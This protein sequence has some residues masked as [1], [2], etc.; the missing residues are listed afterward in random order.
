MN[1]LKVFLFALVV[2]FSAPVFAQTS[3]STNL[4]IV[5]Q[6]VKADKKL[7]VAANMNLSDA[8]AKAFWPVYDAFQA[9]LDLVNRRLGSLIRSYADAY[10]KGN[11]SAEVSRKLIAESLAIEEAETKLKRSYVP[12][13]EK[14]LSATK[15]ARYLQIESQIRTII[16][17]EIA[18]EIPLIY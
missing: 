17:Y 9:D 12:K 5:R 3:A 10:N 16:R 15:V 2:S 14:V 7:V 18:A 1:A 11:I 8:E 13:L 6:K 4:E